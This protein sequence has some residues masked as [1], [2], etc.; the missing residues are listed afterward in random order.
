MK[1]S[2]KQSFGKTA[3]I[4][5]AAAITAVGLS[6]CKQKEKEPAQETSVLAEED[7]TVRA[8]GVDDG[9]LTEEA[10]LIA[11][12][13][14]A[15]TCREAR[16]YLQQVK[17]KYEPTLGEEIWDIIIEDGETFEG[18][19][20]EEVI[21]EITEVK[22]ICQEANKQGI[23]LSDD[24]RMEAEGMAQEYIEKAG[25]SVGITKE[26]A[27]EIYGDHILAGKMFD[28]TT[29]NVDTSI[30]NEEARQITIQYLKVLTNGSDKNGAVVSMNEE[31]K[32]K[33]K[34]QTQTLLEQ[35]KE[36]KSFY[37]FAEANSDDSQVE[38]T[39]GVDTRPDEFG[40][41]A[42][43][44]KAGEFSKVIEGES[45]FYILYCVSDMDEEATSRKKEEIITENQDK[46]FQK[47]YT[48]WSKNYEVI[49]SSTLWDQMRL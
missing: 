15:V 6:G 31:E 17:E 24:E 3:F 1:W 39:F 41:Q 43:A 46:V 32:K 30:S 45:G 14:E 2:A 9:E 49:I 23:L 5:M 47:A 48:E 37:N 25:A 44:L 42:L 26:Q 19:V 20:K 21:S 35:A 16:F 28:V 40:D 11:V 38:I 13:Q 29:G 12:G 7:T 4:L 18:Y 27:A 10:I 22:I 8:V 33:A 36:A 34:E